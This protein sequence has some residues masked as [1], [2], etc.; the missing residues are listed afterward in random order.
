MFCGVHVFFYFQ[1]SGCWTCILREM[2]I[3]FVQMTSSLNNLFARLYLFGRILLNLP[4]RTWS[5]FRSNFG[6]I[7]FFRYSFAVL[8]N[9]RHDPEDRTKRLNCFYVSNV[10]TTILVHYVTWNIFISGRIDTYIRIARGRPKCFLFVWSNYKSIARRMSRD[11][12]RND[13]VYGELN[14]YG[15]ISTCYPLKKSYMTDQ[16]DI[17]NRRKMCKSL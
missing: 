14:F 10:L 13:S 11:W 2:K 4:S 8:Q 5:V 3:V 12:K 1:I 7:Y 17:L 9:E 15:W 6:W 16:I